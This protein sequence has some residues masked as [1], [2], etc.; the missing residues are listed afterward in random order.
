MAIFPAKYNGI[1]FSYDI[2]RES[3]KYDFDAQRLK[4]TI[5]RDGE[6]KYLSFLSNQTDPLISATLTAKSDGV[7]V[8]IY[9]DSEVEVTDGLLIFFKILTNT[10][11]LSNNTYFQLDVVTEGGGTDTIYSECFIV[12]NFIGPTD[13]EICHITAFNNDARHGYLTYAYPAFGFFKFSKLNSDIFINKKTEYE[14]SYGRKKILSSEN[15]I[16]K[17]ITFVNLSMYQQN[18]LKWLCNCENLFI[19]GVK[20]ELISD[21]TE[22]LADENSE[23]KD[24]RADF[25]EAEQSFFATGSQTAPTNVFTGEFFMK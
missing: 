17:R 13:N 6:I 3:E 18:L 20:Y 19:D 4:N 23:I 24:L 10:L 8:V 22:L 9:S 7:D 25:V 5:K 11:N 2:N 21:F 16:A 1:N 14:Y 15:N 12:K